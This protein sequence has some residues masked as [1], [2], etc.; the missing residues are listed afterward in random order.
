MHQLAGLPWNLPGPLCSQAL[1]L[2]SKKQRFFF[3][4]VVRHYQHCPDV[5][6]LWLRSLP[7]TPTCFPLFPSFHGGGRDVFMF[8]LSPHGGSE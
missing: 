2:L 7:I 8:P 6:P 3:V 5:L 4:V 1:L